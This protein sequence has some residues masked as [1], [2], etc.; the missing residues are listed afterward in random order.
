MGKGKRG[1]PRADRARYPSGQVRPEGA[2]ITST[3]LQRLRALGTHPVLETQMGRLLFLGDLDIEQYRTAE[4][5]AK[6]YGRYDRAIGRRRWAASPGY[7]IGHRG[8][9][10][11]ESEDEA[12]RKAVA[13]R[14]FGALQ[15]EMRLCPRGAKAA[16]E[17][18]CID[19]QVCPAGWLPQV[20]IALDMLGEALGL[21][22]RKRS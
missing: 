9:G 2:G 10:R 21:R 19:D 6:L 1:R 8:D 4:H 11:D 18:L 12:K 16:I 7:E 22:R 13:V 15:A 3:Q 5:I 17:A 14:K 20:K